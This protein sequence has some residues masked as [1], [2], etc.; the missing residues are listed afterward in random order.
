MRNGLILLKNNCSVW[1]CSIFFIQ[2]RPDSWDGILDATK[3]APAPIQDTEGMAML[4]DF[5]PELVE[6]H[7]QI[8][9]EDCLYLSVYTSNPSKTANLPVSISIVVANTFDAITFSTV[10]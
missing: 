4:Y 1:Q 9:D 5:M 8:Y 7:P 3:Q 2:F 10:Y 6:E